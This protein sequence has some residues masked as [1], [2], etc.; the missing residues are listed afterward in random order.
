MRKRGIPISETPPSDSRTLSII[1]A[2]A[3]IAH[4]GESSQE[5]PERG[6]ADTDRLPIVITQEWSNLDA[7]PGTM[8][9]HKQQGVF[10]GRTEEGTLVI[11]D[12]ALYLMAPLAYRDVPEW[13][14][15][16]AE[17]NKGEGCVSRRDSGLSSPVPRGVVRQCL[18]DAMRY[19]LAIFRR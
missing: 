15:L 6:L 9:F 13:W 12:A 3:E 5:Q 10:W 2:S 1:T 7:V 17:K 16:L 11:V 4:G 14:I 19:V 18:H 8:L